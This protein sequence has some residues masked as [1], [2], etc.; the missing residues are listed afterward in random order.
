MNNQNP[1]FDKNFFDQSDQNGYTNP[2]NNRYEYVFSSG[3][4]NPNG[5]P[6][7]K[8]NSGR[9]AFAIITVLLSVSLAFVAGFGGAL[10]ATRYLERVEAAPDESNRYNANPSDV[11][12]K[13]QS[14]SSVYG[15][16][17]EDVFAV[18]QVVNR[19]KDAVV[20]I[21]CTNFQSS[22]S[23]S[24]VIVSAE[25]GYIITCHH[26]VDGAA[27][28]TVVATVQVS[29]ENGELV[30]EERRFEAAL[31][32]SDANSDI[33]VIQIATSDNVLLTDVEQ[34]CSADLV[35]GERVVAIGNP[36]GTLGGTVTDGIISATER[37]IQTSDGNVM[38]LLQTDAAI[39]QGN[40]GGGL[41]NLDGQLIG[42]VNAKYAASG[43]EGLAFAVP[44]D[45]AYTVQ[46]A[47]IKDGYV[48]GVPDHGLELSDVTITSQ[49]EAWYYQ[50]FGIY[51][52]GVYVI[53]STVSGDLT[54][55]DRIISI[56][57]ITVTSAYEAEKLLDQYKVG[58]TVQIV[59]SRRGEEFTASLTLREYVPDYIKQPGE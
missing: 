43:V 40:S 16:A 15:S 38:K 39:N 2:S 33:A 18:S 51:A 41:F 55:Y 8:N 13:A 21:E 20:V 19:V 46:L 53:S 42:I 4:Y 54:A 48:R 22:G 7:R 14:N 6:P 28:I 27:N 9:V 12:D 11:L 47:L 23:G 52:S 26:V 29:D 59:A 36:L 5:M 32:G 37:S 44:I 1:H 57:G 45:S 34:G 3:S 35:V 58:D 49:Y 25:E 31:V 56:N 10:F 17:G 24:G 50:R 30:R